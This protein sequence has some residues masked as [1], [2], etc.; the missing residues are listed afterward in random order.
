MA[1][2]THKDLEMTYELLK[3][4]LFIAGNTDI[5]EE[6]EL[7]T[8]YKSRRRLFQWTN[9]GLLVPFPDE[10]FQVMNADMGFKR[11]NQLS[12]KAHILKRDVPLYDDFCH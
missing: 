1:L 2:D 6:D 10:F 7:E 9:E 8:L 5:L 4:A 12:W 11:T 3:H